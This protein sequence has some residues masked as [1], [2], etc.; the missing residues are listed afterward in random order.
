MTC[1][2]T[3]DVKRAALA[4]TLALT[5][6]WSGCF[7]HAEDGCKGC[8]IVPWRSPMPPR[9]PAGKTALVILLHGAFGFGSE[10]VPILA[11]LDRRPELAYFAFAWPG[12]FGGRTTD[13][14][15]A[16]RVTLQAAVSSLPESTREVLVLAHSAGGAVAEYAARRLVVPPYVRVHIALLDASHVSMAP[17]KRVDTVDTPLGIAIGETQQPS[18][19]L[20]PR[21]D[22]EDF[23]ASDPPR[24]PSTSSTSSA[25]PQEI[26]ITQ[27][28]DEKIYYLGRKV[29]HGGSVGLAG[30][31]L[32]EKL[33]R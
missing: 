11:A 17:Y 6:L 24:H 29:T 30:L 18:P 31:P 23:R 22:V 25:R 32:I 16:F 28:S 15:E 14:A 9:T 1:D 19:P 13:R 10:W 12:P 20:P 21:V 33:P 5:A 2:V 8:A 7:V 26:G 27:S 4:C 3:C